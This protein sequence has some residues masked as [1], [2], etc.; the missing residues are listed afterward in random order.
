MG[1]LEEAFEAA[2]ARQGGPQSARPKAVLLELQPQFPGLQLQV[3]NIKWHLQAHRK[4]E[5]RVEE[6]LKDASGTIR[7]TGRLKEAFNAAVA[8]LGGLAAARPR[9]VLQVL[10][11]DFPL[12]TLQNVKWHLQ[13]LRKKEAPGGGGERTTA[14]THSSGSLDASEGT[15]RGG[16]TVS[17]GPPRQAQQAAPTRAL[18]MTSGGCASA[19]Q[20]HP[21]RR[22]R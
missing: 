6:W 10:Q 21:P 22:G 3:Q 19:R 17:Q 15:E 5:E 20:R 9:T 2:V 13:T 11:A 14:A 7:W 16:Q 1:R 12:L 4:R 8:D 18:A